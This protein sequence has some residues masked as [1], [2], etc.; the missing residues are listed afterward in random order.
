MSKQD[1]PN[2]LRLFKQAS[3]LAPQY[4]E[5]RI[6][7]AIGALYSKDVKLADSILSEVNPQTLVNDDRLLSTYAALGMY[8]RVLAMWQARINADPKNPQFRLSLA[9]TFLKLN[10]RDDAISTLQTLITAE[11]Q[12]ATQL[13]GYITQIK[14]GKNPIQ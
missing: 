2:A 9:A 3:D 14:A 8:D 12:Y 5:A 7:Y 6:I 10:R 1:Y 11:P 13:Q 4:A